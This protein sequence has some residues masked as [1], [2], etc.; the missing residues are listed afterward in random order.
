MVVFSASLAAYEMR[1]MKGFNQIRINIRDRFS[2]LLLTVP[3]ND[4]ALKM[5]LSGQ[6]KWLYMP[7]RVH[8]LYSARKEYTQ[9]SCRLTIWLFLVHGCTDLYVYV[10]LSPLLLSLILRSSEILVFIVY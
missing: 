10:H 8:T 5:T 9:V 2:F 3:F 7:Q 6:R 4:H 1:I